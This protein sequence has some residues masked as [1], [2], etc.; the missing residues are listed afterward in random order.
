MFII[1]FPVNAPV[2]EKDLGAVFL[3]ND[4]PK[5]PGEHGSW[6]GGTI[7]G[8]NTQ[9]QIG[10]WGDEPFSVHVGPVN[11]QENDA[12]EG[13][14]NDEP[15]STPR[16]QE[17]VDRWEAEP[18]PAQDTDDIEDS[19]ATGPI[20]D[21]NIQNTYS[22]EGAIV[23]DNWST[24]GGHD[25][26][27]S[28]S[29]EPLNVQETP[30]VDASWATHS[31]PVMIDQI[32][33]EL[34][35]SGSD[36][37]Q[38]GGKLEE[39][40]MAQTTQNREESPSTAFWDFEPKPEQNVD[41]DG[42]RWQSEIEP[43]QNYNTRDGIWATETLPGEINEQSDGHWLVEENPS[44]TALD[45]RVQTDELMSAQNPSESLWLP[46]PGPDQTI[47]SSEGRWDVDPVKTQIPQA[48][49]DL[50]ADSSN[51]ASSWPRRNYDRNRT[52]LLSELLIPPPADALK[53]DWS[54]LSTQH[55][56]ASTD[57]VLDSNDENYMQSMDES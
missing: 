26:G 53:D 22:P 6:T 18:I 48:S 21:D 39:Q 50:W 25:Q 54:L 45:S 35:G 36:V 17:L 27:G 4:H 3:T 23:A 41:S 33:D 16:V 20:F 46:L 52:L 37:H 32:T 28:W 34:L 49:S 14:W 5:L 51:H 47:D 24:R 11:V 8:Q 56:T 42:G 13:S 7:N 1:D 19:W 57:S 15:V 9:G 40:W 2:E 12:P 31:N 10:S 55:N 38:N 44:Q 29:T 30:E 43:A